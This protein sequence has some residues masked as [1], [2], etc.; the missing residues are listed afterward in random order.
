MKTIIIATLLFAA[1]LAANLADFKQFMKA[2]GKTYE[3]TAEFDHRFHVFKKN[4]Q[5]AKDASAKHPKARF[6]ATK[7][8]DLA[9]EE[10]KA[11]YLPG[12][13]PMGITNPSWP[14]A[15]LY[16]EKELQ[17]A[18]STWDWRDHGA[19]T[20]IKNQGQCGSCWSFSTTGNVEGQWFLAGNSLVGLSEQNL[21]DCDTRDSGCDGGLMSNAFMYIMQNNGIDT[22]AS[23]PYT[24]EDGTC[25]FNAKNVGAKIDNWTMIASNETQMA[26]YCGN[27]GPISIAVDA[28]AW[29]FYLGGVFDDPWCGTTLDHGVLIVGYA[30]ETDIFGLFTEYWI[31]KNSWGPDWGEAGY[32]F[33]EKGSDSCGDNIFPCSSIINKSTY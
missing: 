32:I 21:V 10:F 20:P 4:M 14:I 15:P 24:A 16:S 23:Y 17:A 8:A 18:P 12:E 2:H 29:Q 33:L 11:M 7:F 27:N 5:L 9:P 3:T 31:V 13:Y 25:K 1:A 28:E 22:E 26:A 6:G 30:N 19:V